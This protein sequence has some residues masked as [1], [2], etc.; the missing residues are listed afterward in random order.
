GSS[1]L[2]P[3]R[4]IVRI[5]ATASTEAVKPRIAGYARVS[6]DSA[7]QLNSFSAQV[8]Y[9][10]KLIESHSE[11]E[12]A[13]VYAD[14]GTTG[15]STE[16]RDDFNRMLA[17]CR[18]GLINRIIT[19]STSRFARNTLDAIS[20]IRELK[21]IGV[22]VRFEK[23][24]L[25]TASLTSE[26]LLTLYSLFAQEESISISKNCKKGNRIRMEKG[27]YVS[28]N[29]PYGYRLVENQLEICE[30][31][32]EIIRRIFAEYLGGSGSF[33]IAKGLTADGIP[34]RE[35][36]LNWR[37][38]AIVN[39]I[40]NERYAGDMLLQKSYNED[41]MPYRKRENKGELPKYYV[42]NTHEP[43]VGRMEFELANILLKERSTAI[44][45]RT[46]AE[47][48]L[49]RMVRCEECG[50]A[51]RRKITK[52]IPY[53]VCRRHDNDKALCNS[54]RITEEAMH[55][56]FARLYNKLKQSYA[57]ILLPMLS[58]LEKL[59]ELKTRGNPA[60]NTI[61]K[62]IA[63]LS[64]QNHVMTGLLSK[65]ILDSALFISQ[66]DELNRKIRTL[67]QTKARLL[68]E[69]ESDGVLEKTEDLVEIIENGPD[70]IS[71]ME[72]T[73]FREMVE[74]ITA[75]DACT[76]NFTLINGLVLTERL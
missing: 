62:Q 26:N 2:N 59:Q 35:G 75:H 6:S 68:A 66:T 31:E 44:G 61:N 49:S 51:Y 25:D 54:E 76:V 47:Y 30:P 69:Q 14:E 4:E 24:N 7:D 22:T 21:E 39:M 72:K 57:S 36:R 74:Q 18:K 48:P 50:G 19:K 37:Q 60:I 9:Y 42:K 52:Q 46:G 33:E 1:A 53:W 28:S 58:Q 40:R 64:E 27:T 11:W 73:L 32:A 63:D 5:K 15:V 45:S 29:P 56:A 70:R 13:G 34:F 10:T 16:K 67:K 23:E 3:Q 43:I 71:G 17:D 8:R 65:G 20:V 38:Q 55:G 41:A 12:F